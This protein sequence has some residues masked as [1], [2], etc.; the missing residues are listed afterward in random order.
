MAAVLNNQ[1]SVEKIKF[2]MEECQR[3]ELP[4]RGPDVNESLKGFSVNS[5]GVVRFGMNAVKGVG[6]AAVEDIIKEREEAG[7]YLS[8]YD[9]MCRINQKTVNKK[10]LESLVYA[11][12]LDS[13]KELHRAQYFFAPPVDPVSGLERLVRFGNQYQG[14]KAMASNSLFGEVAMPDVK[15]PVIPECEPWNISDLL[16]REK[17]VVGIYIS[18]HPLDGFKFELQHYNFLPV[19]QLE[20]NKGKVVRLAGYISDVAHR[21]TKK[22]TKFGSFNLNDYSGHQ[23][24]T[25]WEKEYVQWGNYLEN[26]TKVVI[27]GVWGEHRFRPGVM[28]FSIQNISLL[29]AVRK[30]QTKRISLG[31]KMEQLN[32]EFISFITQN[33]KQSP[34]NTELC[35]QIRDDEA[36]HKLR[37]RTNGQKFA[38]DD[39]FV[40]F[41]EQ[42]PDILYHIETM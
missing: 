20:A 17:E 41:L 11:G 21:V 6:E 33:V 7:P 40:H 12:A 39:A 42:R 13:F 24:F 28:E 1:G 23:E 36:D 25:L 38:P 34:G 4:V 9:F 35:I 18:A 8:V 31:L 37:L 14:S 3:M 10:T 5:E 29:S 15:P 27:Q 30:A 32:E 22:G 16:E 26:G 2:H 19:N